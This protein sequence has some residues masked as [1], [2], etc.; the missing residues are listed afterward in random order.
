MIRLLAA[1]LA[2]LSVPLA[3]ADCYSERRGAGSGHYALKEGLAHDERTNLTWARCEI[4]QIWQGTACAGESRLRPKEIPLAREKESRQ[5]EIWTTPLDWH[6]GN[7]LVGDKRT[8]SCISCLACE[9]FFERTR[10]YWLVASDPAI[11][12]TASKSHLV[13][14]FSCRWVAYRRSSVASSTQASQ[15]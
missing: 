1:V 4:G 6:L 15:D 13:V 9:R 7:Y 8:L 3:R 12:H 2:L 5:S 10:E 14:N 11:I